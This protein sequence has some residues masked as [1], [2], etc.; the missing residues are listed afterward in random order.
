[1]ARALHSEFVSSDVE[2]TP[3]RQGSALLAAAGVVAV[4]LLVASGVALV[5]RPS[6][7]S[8]GGAGSNDTEDMGFNGSA[9]AGTDGSTPASGG[10]TPGSGSAPTAR[11]ASTAAW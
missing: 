7:G 11:P 4:G 10:S 9:V 3:R 8:T 6:H 2:H 1:M 5:L